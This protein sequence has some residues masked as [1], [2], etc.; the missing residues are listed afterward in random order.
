MKKIIKKLRKK[1][2]NSGSSIVL[3]VVG[4]GFIGVLVGALLTAAGYA[5]RQKVY[6]YNSKDNFFYLEKAMDEVYAGIGD[7]TMDA[8]KAAYDETVNEVVYF[9]PKTKSYETMDRDEANKHFKESFMNKVYN[10]PIFLSDAD[11][12]EYIE[13]V[14]SND[15]VKVDGIPRVVI[16]DGAGN[17]YASKIGITTVSK[18][19]ITDLVLSRTADYNRSNVRNSFT[20]TIS[21][22]IEISQPDFD[23]QFGTSNIDLSNVFDYAMIAGDGVEIHQKTTGTNTITVK[24]NV[25]AA[26]DY[27]NKGYATNTNVTGKEFEYSY[28]N[29]KDDKDKKTKSKVNA[30]VNTDLLSAY[31][32][33]TPESKYSGVY[34]DG[35]SVAFLSDYLVVPGTFAVMN[36]GALSVYNKN[37]NT[38]G[39]SRV[40]CDDFVLGGTS[41]ANTDGSYSGSSALIRG[42]LFIQ[43]DLQLDAN[44]SNF[45]MSGSYIGYNNSSTSDKREYLPDV[46]EKLYKDSEG[47]RKGHFNSSAISINGLA[48]SLDFESVDNLYL[49]GK[50]YIEHSKRRTVNT[51]TNTI[52]YL[53]NSTIDD[54]K[55]GESIAVKSNQLAYIPVNYNSQVYLWD[56]NKN[57]VYDEG[58]DQFLVSIGKP[59]SSSMLF[60]DHFPTI[61]L[62]GPTQSPGFNTG[63]VYKFDISKTPKDG[64]ADGF[65]SMITSGVTLRNCIFVNV[66]AIPVSSNAANSNTKNFVYYNFDRNY[67]LV[68]NYI[69]DGASN[70]ATCQAAANYYNDHEITSADEL[71]KDFI[72]SYTAAILDGNSATAT[73]TEKELAAALTDITNFEGYA[74]EAGEARIDPAYIKYVDGKEDFNHESYFAGG[75]ITASEKASFKM[76][77]ANEQF[78]LDSVI[79]GVDEKAGDKTK[80]SDLANNLNK[81]YN[82]LKFSLQELNPKADTD[83]AKTEAIDTYLA[84]D[85]GKAETAISPINTYFNFDQLTENVIKLDGYAVVSSKQ[86]NILLRDNVDGVADGVFKGIIFTSGRVTFDPS[87]QKFEGM[88]VAGDKIMIPEDGTVTNI[89]ANAEMCKEIIRELQ[90]SSND[91]AGSILKIFKGY[92][93]VVPKKPADV[94]EAGKI[95]YLDYSSVVKYSNWMK[96]VT[97]EY[98]K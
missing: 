26:A 54:Y 78:S 46:D 1:L 22:D 41:L 83:K 35:S 53:Y 27:Y 43:D 57:G 2:N 72:A 90:F 30:T 52:A 8:L 67:Q 34:I 23:V 15:S 48:S 36:R 32:G 63:N 6:N 60:T 19:V 93:S 10:N 75:A 45:G 84:M 74:D 97:E 71:R 29:I 73:P 33:E 16:Y 42:D 13:S 5:L 20:Q 86:D 76:L 77:V 55:T 47:K 28:L 24:G 44:G 9:N 58:E 25:Y 50:S 49:G 14:I 82:Y 39:K 70:A 65:D 37:G 61:T 56:S 85:G 40:W 79:A 98:G 21:T 96:N 95:E 68:R 88:I 38:I 51:T 59:Y 66:K 94:T 18:V 4:L 62:S 81:R 92:E 7:Q 17:P 80:A 64:T 12:K 89:T 91:A 31:R 11:T 69:S 87:V 3:V